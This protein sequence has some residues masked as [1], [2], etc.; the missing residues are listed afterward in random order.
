[1][2]A[3]PPVVAVANLKGGVGKSTTALMLAEGLAFHYGLHVLL[4]DFDAQANLSETILT[5]DGVQRELNQGRG[6][7]AV[8]DGFLPRDSRANP[9]L[10]DVVE[11]RNSTVVEELVW[12]RQRGDRDGWVN[13]LPAHPGLRFLEPHLERS[14][15]DGWF[16]IGDELARRVLSTTAP[17]RRNCDLVIIDCPPHVSALCRAALKLADYFVTPTLAEALSVW[18]VHQFL[19][20]LAHPSMSDWLGTDP[21]TLP[22]RQFVVCTR[23]SARS[24]SHHKQIGRLKEDWPGRRFADPIRQRVSLSRELERTDLDSVHSFGSR[25]RGQVKSD[26]ASLAAAFAAFI[27]EREQVEWKK[28]R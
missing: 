13:L 27:A 11:T 12:K 23:F 10:A 24:R 3:R 9:D 2:A 8:L 18:G 16:E 17:V 14:P 19:R 4:C 20:W 7:A 26:V 5:S 21:A 22:E 1:M 25:Y 15:G 28:R 6:L